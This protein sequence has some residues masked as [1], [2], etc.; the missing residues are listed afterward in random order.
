[1][2]VMHF[3]AEVAPVIINHAANN[4][5][6]PMHWAARHGLP[7]VVRLIHKAAGEYEEALESL[8]K[9]QASYPRDR[10]VLNEIARILFLR[11]EFAEAVS[12][13]DEV[14]RIDPEDLQLHYTR[15][16][17]FRG[18]GDTEEAEREEKLFLRFK[19]D[20]SSQT[21][22]AKIRRLSPELNNER[23]AIHEHTSIP[24]E[25]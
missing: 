16:L 20:E 17:C 15:M 5:R 13:L 24:L 22:T 3:I 14:S 19:A 7:E 2:G 23:Q 11:R 8:R 10:V 1:M 4:G 6:R 12:V 21:K 9:A 25:R 18:L